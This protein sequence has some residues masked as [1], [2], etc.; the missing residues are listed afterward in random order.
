MS[1]HVKA[2]FLI[3]VLALW[4]VP[5]GCSRRAQEGAQGEDASADL[6]HA[7]ELWTQM[8]G[9]ET[10]A[11]P[12]GFEGWQEGK[13][14][15]GAVLRYYLNEIAQDDLTADGAVLVKENYSEESK[16]AL[17]SVTVMEKREGY[18]PETGNWFYVKYGP[19]GEVLA[20]PKGKKL[21]GLVGKGGAKGCIPCHGAAAGDDYLFMND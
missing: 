3:P 18:A 6:Q 4:L 19:E 11:E 14:P 1:H 17:M 7:R 16:D 12:E 2:L 21:A 15:H 8:A 20:N 9:Y 10:W 13:S 5:A